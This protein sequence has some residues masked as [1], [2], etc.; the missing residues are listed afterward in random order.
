MSIQIEQ[1]IT[2]EQALDE[3]TSTEGRGVYAS[4]DL[5]FKGAVFGRDSL[6]VAQDLMDIK[7]E[8]VENV[9]MTL[10]SLQGATNNALRDEQ[11]GRIIHEYRNHIVDGVPME[12]VSKLLF[13]ELAAK[14]DGTE[15]EVI[16]YGSVDSTPLFISVICEFVNKYGEDIL[17]KTVHNQAGDDYTVRESLV[18]ATEWLVGR[19]EASP[20]GLLMHSTSNPEGGQ[21]NQVWKD[22]QEFYIHADGNIVNYEHPVASIEVQ[23]LAYDA[24]LDASAV[25]QD[26]QQLLLKQ[27]EDLQRQTIQTL[28]MPE[29]NYFALGLDFKAEGKTRQIKTLTAN[30]GQLLDTKLFDNLP[31]EERQRY[32]SAIVTMLC[33][34]EF[35]TDAGIRSR[36]LSGANLIPFWDYHGSYV[37]WPKETNDIARGMRKHG[38]GQL[39]EQLENRVM[40]V[41]QRSG[42]FPEY[43]YV[44][45]DGKVL[46]DLDENDD[47]AFVIE[48]TNKPERTQAWTISAVMSTIYRKLV[49][50]SGVPDDSWQHTLE[51]KLIRH[52]PEIPFIRDSQQLQ[53]L[54]PEAPYKLK[55]QNPLAAS[56]FLDQLHERIRSQ[57]TD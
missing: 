16:Y 10:A 20:S 52:L 14:W 32:V 36:A 13:E 50:V 56:Y 49:M 2:P 44:D 17:Q 5:L 1:T 38:L 21:K 40:N 11:P 42:C 22:S 9:I 26:R 43:I 53:T 33:S 27:A 15:R 31:D 57:K 51:T 25:M 55:K 8:L 39:A 24:L 19:L 41:V 35:M 47:D 45:A 12:G 28:W 37:T 29:K 34:D 4:G 7:P 30:P 46:L 6:E 48:G 54:Y 3:I 23:G 18:R